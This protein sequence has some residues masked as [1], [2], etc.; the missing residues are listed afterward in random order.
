MVLVT[1]RVELLPLASESEL[2]GNG[3][4]NRHIEALSPHPA[5]CTWQGYLDMAGLLIEYG[6]SITATDQYGKDAQDYA[7]A[8]GYVDLAKVHPSAPQAVTLLMLLL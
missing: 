7:A 8:G 5:L 1:H 4:V 6:A 2:T 3:L